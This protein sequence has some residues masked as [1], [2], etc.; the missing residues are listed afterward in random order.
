MMLHRSVVY[1][2]GPKLSGYAASSTITTAVAQNAADGCLR[3]G[4]IWFHDIPEFDLG[5]DDHY[6]HDRI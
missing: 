2:Y 3:E 1:R 6:L 5:C 4:V